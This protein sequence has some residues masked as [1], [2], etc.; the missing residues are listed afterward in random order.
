MLGFMI[1]CRD[2]VT[3]VSLLGQLLL[4]VILDLTVGQ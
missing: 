3:A 2:A 1:W 4:W